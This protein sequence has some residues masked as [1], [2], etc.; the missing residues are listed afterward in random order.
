M[1]SGTPRIVESSCPIRI[2]DLGGWTDT[3]FAGHGEVL[4]IAVTPRVRCRIEAS[5]WTGDD[6]RRVTLRAL[7]YGDVW[8]MDPVQPT[9]LGR[10]ALLEESVAE[11]GVPDGRALDISIT[12][13]VPGGCA[14]GTSASV[15]VALLGAL[16]HLAGDS[17]EP[18]ALAARAQQVETVRLGQQCGIQDQFAAACGGVLH[19][20]MDRYP[21]AT[22]DP[23]ALPEPL[24]AQLNRR[25]LLVYLGQT[26]ESSEVHERVIHR[27]EHEGVESPA[28][29]RLRAMPGRGLDALEAGDLAAFGRVMIDN[30]EAQASL[31][32]E[33]VSQTA[34][35]VIELA[36][37]HDALG[38][39][40]NG[41]GGEGGSL[42][43]LAP[44]NSTRLTAL[45]DAVN[46]LGG[47]VCVIPTE[48]SSQGLQ[49]DEVPTR[50]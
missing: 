10:H 33:L 34:R 3:W 18:E 19:I 12:S 17:A 5:A 24:L 39:K 9:T 36:R 15:T 46:A 28:L 44:E 40:V 26:H 35:R 30:T 47:G 4:S 31:H 29:A 23:L 41:A 2:C 49:I 16:A 50:I 21:H 8:R 22:V 14:T 25:L 6:P 38:W 7:D 42:T 37:G 48:L 11:I 1:E 13:G 20:H 32:D 43:L 45:I 27:L